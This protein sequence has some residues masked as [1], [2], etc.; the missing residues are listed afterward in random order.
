MAR[1]KN[2]E[3]DNF[4][5]SKYQK[6]IF[7]FIQNEKGNLL[8]EAVAGSG[9]T[10]TI[11][12]AL[13][14]IPDD[15]SVLFCAFNKDIVKDLTKKTKGLKNIEVR[16]IHGLGYII[17]I[18]N[19]PTISRKID[20][21]KYFQEFITNF[22]KYTK[23]SQTH[24]GY[25]K[26][27]KFRK[28]VCKLIDLSRL[29]L[30][31]QP[32]EIT[33]IANYYGID[34][35][36]DEENTVVKLME[37]GKINTKSMDYT[38]MVWY[39]NIFD[40]DL[41]RASFDY[42]FVDEAQDLSKAQREFI[43]K[44]NNNS[45]RYAFVGDG[46]QSIYGFSAADPESFNEIKK[47]NDITILPLSVCYRCPKEIVNF[48]NALVPE[49][50]AADDAIRGTIEAHS[51]LDNIEDQDMILC[52]YNAPLLSAYTK[53]ISKG[54]KTYIMG[55]D[56]G[57]NL[58]DIIQSTQHSNLYLDLTQKGVFSALYKDYF[59]KRNQLIKSNGWTAEMA[60]SSPLLLSMQDN[61]FALEV[62]AQG[63]STTAQLID[64]ISKIFSD[65]G[66]EGIKLSTIHKAKGLESNN[67]YIIDSDS[68]KRDESKM[69]NWEKQQEKNL[70]YV[71]YTRPKKKL[72][73]I[74]DNDICNV[75]PNQ[76]HNGHGESITNYLN[77]IE[78]IIDELYSSKTN[79]IR[80]N[81]AIG[82]NGKTLGHTPRRTHNQ[83]LK[84]GI[85]GANKRKKI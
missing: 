79:P 75:K 66:S 18:E 7:D 28:N 40:F 9:K 56:I 53:L 77:K 24:L 64:K 14:L 76:F 78:K 33:T 60:D 15:K 25:Q 27:V 34:L 37:W 8:I 42:I 58:I 43:L 12:K 68:F 3:C 80:L 48:A 41:S 19:L 62:V 51:Q 2:T 6:Q 22:Y 44:C 63:V 32:Q 38:D 55:K 23:N 50:E 13:N 4:T 85:L 67:V 31:T 61:I 46:N 26:W 57:S 74:K 47:I 5:P 39:P 72:G 11:V 30:V 82:S 1:K 84:F 36:G 83:P 16:T 49:I 65:D 52:R 69:T 21:N 73:F 81:T 70:K 59:N 35:I 29:N 54:K 17:C 10:T 20:V 45:T 71:A